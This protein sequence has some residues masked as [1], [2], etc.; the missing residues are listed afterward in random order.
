PDAELP[1]FPT[2]RS[3]DLCILAVGNIHF[4][5]LEGHLGTALAIFAAIALE[6][7]LS[8]YATG[9]W[10]HLASCYITGISV[11]ILPRTTLLWPYVID[12]KSTRLNSSHLGI[13]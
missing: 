13:S 10:P 4:G 9:K 11:G 7:V 1:S 12:R 8:K 2:R 5:I 6:L 3:S